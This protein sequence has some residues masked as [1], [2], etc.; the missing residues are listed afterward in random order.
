MSHRRLLDDLALFPISTGTDRDDYVPPWRFQFLLDRARYCSEHAKNAQRD[1]LNFLNNGETEG[2]K[3][4]SASQTVEL[5]KASVQLET[6]CVDLATSE[7]AAARSAADG[8][9][10]HAKNAGEAVTEYSDFEQQANE[11]DAV[12]E[13][14]SIF[15]D[16]VKIGESAIQENP[17]GVIA[18]GLELAG[19]VAQGSVKQ[20]QRALERLTLERSAVEATAATADALQKLDVARSSFVVAGL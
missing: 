14:R 13:L 18:G 19:T 1:Y 15:G 4:L 10:L 11:A 17:I 16:L 5:E 9:A 3:E 6:A 2:C 7:I 12:A 8:A 20:A